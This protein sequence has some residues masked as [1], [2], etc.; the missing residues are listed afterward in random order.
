MDFPGEKSLRITKKRKKNGTVNICN[1]EI[2][3][4]AER[5]IK[6]GE[7]RVRREFQEIQIEV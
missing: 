1:T 7:L 5:H 2:K 4:R 6:R 3:D